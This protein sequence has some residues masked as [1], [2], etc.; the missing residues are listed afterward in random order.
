[1]TI[2]QTI[3]TAIGSA[4]EELQKSGALTLSAPTP[5]FNVEPPREAAHGDLATN[6][7]M[8]LTKIAGKPPRAIAEMLKPKLE[9]HPAITAVEIAGPGFINLRLKPEVWQNELKEIL[10]S[11]I[12]Y[13]D[14]NL[15]KHEKVN[16]EFV[17][18]NPT[19][20]MH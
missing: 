11:G 14:S 9:A 4:I 3:H 10:K 5:N 17:S 20:P 19:G 7:A 15:G 1:M 8:T 2:F 6:V 18:V 13:G 16:V 12:H